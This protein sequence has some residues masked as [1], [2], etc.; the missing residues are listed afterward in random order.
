MMNELIRL[1]PIHIAGVF[2]IILLL[3]PTPINRSANVSVLAARTA[4]MAGRSDAALEHLETV[5]EYYPDNLRYRISAAEIAFSI[6]EFDRVL[7]H[8]ARIKGNL[9][10][11]KDL[12]CIQAET[13]LSLGNV[14]KALQ[15]W[16]SA[17][18]DCPFFD[19]NLLP[20]VYE[21]IEDEE[22]KQAGNILRILS[23]T[24][25]LNPDVH[26]LIGTLTATYAPEE[27]L[28]SLRLADDLSDNQNLPAQELYRMIE[29][30]RA[31]NHL[32][33]SIAIV[34]KYFANNGDWK[35]AIL[36]FQ[37]AITLQPD[38]ADAYAF[39]GLAL[40]QVDRNG[41]IQLLE[42]VELAPDNP[43]PHLYLGIHWLLKTESVMAMN[44]FERAIE[45]DPDNPAILVQIGAAYESQGEIN[46]AIQA[47][48]TAAEVNPQ[49]PDFWLLLAKVSLKNE[50]QVSQIAL[51]AARNALVLNPDHAP[52]VD[53]LGY[54]YY[55]LGD[56]IFA[57]RFIRRALDLDPFLASAQ[58]HIGLLHLQLD[59]DEA[60]IAAFQYAHELDPNG[61]VGLLAQQSL[62][63]ILP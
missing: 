10:V 13:L 11:E 55:L 52:A 4:A 56:M 5:L 51:P 16:E 15:F 38:Y 17:D 9:Q 54:S 53:A 29:D 46:L 30:A 62:E 3:S 45:L 43:I 12:L 61:K 39:L 41:I 8:I 22:Y 18:R 34:G 63:T 44:E 37:N 21:L 31:Y 33:Y 36:A 1:R 49:D 58:Y 40:D 23:E 48:L 32:A 7:Y 20:L 35:L 2:I 14:E 25:P 19:E 6:G 60:A 26:F 57:E 24:Q 47:Y 59:E 28:V 42:A 27:A 50:F